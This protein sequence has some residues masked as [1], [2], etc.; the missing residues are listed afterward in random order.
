MSDFFE[1][2]CRGLRLLEEENK[3]RW[4]AEDGDGKWHVSDLTGCPRYALQRRKGTLPTNTK[5]IENLLVMEAGKDMHE[6]IQDAHRRAGTLVR[7]DFA[8]SPWTVTAP[9]LRG[10][11]DLLTLISPERGMELWDIKSLKEG[12]YRNKGH[13]IDRIRDEDGAQLNVYMGL[14]G[15]KRGGIVY[16]NRNSGEFTDIE[17]HYDPNLFEKSMQALRM[18]KRWESDGTM[19]DPLDADRFP[20]TYTT[21]DKIRVDCQYYSLCHPDRAVASKMREVAVAATG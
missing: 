9:D 14:T 11:P 7:A 5:P 19:P 8:A 6:R 17:W 3:R 4:A 2:T 15:V 1:A 21:R 20:C 12:G 10:H 18:L 13:V 16:V